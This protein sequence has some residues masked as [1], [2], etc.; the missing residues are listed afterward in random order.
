MYTYRL[1]NLAILCTY[2]CTCVESCF[3]NQRICCV[4]KLF[5]RPEASGVTG[6]MALTTKGTPAV[7][8]QVL[9][10]AQNSS[11]QGPPSSAAAWG[12][13]PVASN[14]LAKHA[15]SRNL[16]SDMT[17]VDGQR[18]GRPVVLY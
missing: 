18:N 5:V 9:H 15:A 8:L 3:H 7:R 1:D 12:D 10:S 16:V 6:A 17:I 13:L 2:R 4:E 11:C 14:F